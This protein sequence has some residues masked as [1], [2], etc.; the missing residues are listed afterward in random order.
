M[1]LLAP[2]RGTHTYWTDKDPVIF[3][4]VICLTK[5]RLFPGSLEYFIGDGVHKY[6][7]LPKY[8]G[9]EASILSKAY[10]LVLRNA[11]GKI[12]LDS[13]DL[14]DATPTSKGVVKA[15]VTKAGDNVVKADANGGLGGW[16]DAISDAVA[17]PSTGLIKNSDGTLGV[18]FEQM[19]TTKFEALL[20]SLKMLIPL[21]TDKAFYV[22]QEH[23]NASDN[24]E[25]II[26]GDTAYN[27]GSEQYPF[28]TIQACINYVT[29]TYSVGTRRP[30]IRVVRGSQQLAYNENLTLPTYARTSGYITLQAADDTAP[31][32]INNVGAIT[33][34]IEIS[35]ETWIL[36]RLIIHNTATDPNNGLS[37]FPSAIYCY[38]GST[39]LYSY[40]CAISQEYVG[41]APA[42]GWVE[43]RTV[44]IE[45]G[46]TFVF[47]VIAG[48]QNSLSCVKGNANRAVMLQ[49]SRKAKILFTS[50]NTT[51][52][53]ICYDIPC[54]GTVTVFAAAGSASSM[55]GAGG[56]LHRVAFSGSVTG[57]TYVITGG[58][59]IG[60][61]VGGFPATG[62]GSVE[63]ETYCWYKQ[64]S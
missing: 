28:K 11:D 1:R 57:N 20:K 4:G 54:S 18:D 38:G 29:Q 39:T 24:T 5:D 34:T 41:A 19:P 23:A 42:S 3:E 63:T 46:A 37:N 43:P 9:A 10:T 62:T 15:S 8:G 56:G 22:N 30:T 40:G 47:S 50:A 12:E 16:K 35:G 25:D 49:S 2:S 33:R 60:A 17:N 31:P 14:P 26:V 13:L 44:E 51:D 55:E 36:R 48:Y 59:Y 52:D 27:R 61:P 45:D 58:A 32:T 21:T 64:E 7:E 53:G 6:S